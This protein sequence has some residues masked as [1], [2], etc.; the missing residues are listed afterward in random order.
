MPHSIIAIDGPAASGKSTT[1]RLLAKKLG[2]LFVSSGH[3]FRSIAWKAHEDHLNASIPKK[4][5]AWL[6]TLELQH[7]VIDGTVH[8]LLNGK[9]LTEHLT[10]PVVNAH[11]STL[12]AIPSVR[13]FLLSQQQ[14]LGKYHNLV[15]E[16]RDIG[17]VIFPDT[18]F[19]FYLDASPEER[20]RRRAKEG[21]SDS[22][23]QRDYQDSTRTVAPLVI[24]PGATV[25]DTTLLNVEQVVEKILSLLKEKKLS[26]LV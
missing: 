18:P 21:E 16:G 12:A 17:S 25:I 9:D 7:K 20:L 23:A 22:I 5:D 24:A 14:D 8:L 26:A 13:D 6:A 19:K 4:I 15:M 11:V 3:F 10:D 1:A 2:F